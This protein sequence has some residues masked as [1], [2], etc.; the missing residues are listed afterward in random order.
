[1]TGRTFKSIL[2]GLGLSCAALAPLSAASVSL[3]QKDGVWWLVNAQGEPFVSIGINHLEPKMYLE[4]AN[5]AHTLETY[6]PDLLN[7]HGDFDYESPAAAQWWA[8]V[9]A[10]LQDFGINSIGFHTYGLL[11]E[12]MRP[13]YYYFARLRVARPLVPHRLDEGA[14]VAERYDLFSDVFWADFREQ[15]ASQV[16]RYRGH[17]RLLGYMVVNFPWWEPRPSTLEAHPDYAFMHPFIQQLRGLPADAPGKQAWV[18]CLRSLYPDAESAAAVYG[19]SLLDWSGFADQTEW[20]QWSAPDQ[21]QADSEAFLRVAAERYYRTLHAIIDGADSERLIFA[22]FRVVSDSGAWF[23]PIMGRYHDVIAVEAYMPFDEAQAALE[24]TYRASGRP[25]LNADAGFAAL[26]DPH[27]E[28]GVKGHKVATRAE[29]G[30]LYAQTLEDLMRQPYMLGYHWCG[31]IAQWDDPERE[32][33]INENGLVDPFGEP[34]PEITN[35]FSAANR[36]AKQWHE[37]AHHDSP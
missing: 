27:Q 32:Q 34:Y 8:D 6:G 20:P 4:S 23:T 24:E 13:D 37:Q 35:P 12:W 11:D 36:Q 14:S 33:R 15:V 28:H 26:G 18:D 30:A 22:R 29:A 16:E 5:R 1:M 3:E 31:Y 17:E 25:L 21:V 19:V 7:E 10:Q 9:Q 2:G